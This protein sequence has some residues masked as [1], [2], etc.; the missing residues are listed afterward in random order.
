MEWKEKWTL[1]MRFIEGMLEAADDK[2]SIRSLEIILDKM[3][4]LAEK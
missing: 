1:L 2:E 3:D 4:K